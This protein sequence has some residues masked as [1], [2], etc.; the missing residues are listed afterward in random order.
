MITIITAS[1]CSAP[2][3]TDFTAHAVCTHEAPTNG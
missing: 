1:A 2:G 3:S